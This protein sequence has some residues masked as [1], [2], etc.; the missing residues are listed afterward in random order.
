MEEVPVSLATWNVLSPSIY[1]KH[2]WDLKISLVIVTSS[3]GFMHLKVVRQGS[4]DAWVPFPI[5]WNSH[6]WQRTC[7]QVLP[8]PIMAFLCSQWPSFFLITPDPS[9]L[10]RE[11]GRVYV[12]VPS[13][14]QLM[15]GGRERSISRS[16][17]YP[18]LCKARRRP[19][20][21]LNAQ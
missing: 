2:H 5:R 16:H 3:I 21:L 19:Q 6:L 12:P 17:Q 18:E 8:A 4:L 20:C 14:T 10:I 7:S 11:G 9:G 15:T 13:S 1:F